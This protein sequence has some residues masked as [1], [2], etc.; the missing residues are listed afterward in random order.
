M[1][2]VI[3]SR[4]APHTKWFTS[5]TRH[6][7]HLQRCLQPNYF[8]SSRGKS[9]SRE[10]YSLIFVYGTALDFRTYC[11]DEQLQENCSCFLLQS[12][13]GVDF[14][15]AN[16]RLFAGLHLPVLISCHTSHEIRADKRS[17][18]LWLIILRGSSTAESSLPHDLSLIELSLLSQ[19]SN[20]FTN[21]LTQS[22]T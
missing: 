3:P 7:T 15:T 9:V 2:Q 10:Q 19:R 16:P 13:T 21:R 6:Q 4:I 14:R 8:R 22:N 1:S 11:K 18:R 17:D 20:V 12:H 5:S